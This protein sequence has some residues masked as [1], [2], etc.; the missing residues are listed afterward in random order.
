MIDSVLLRKGLRILVRR[1]LILG[2]LGCVGIT[3]YWYFCEPCHHGW[4][5]DLHRNVDR[6]NGWIECQTRRSTNDEW[7]LPRPIFV[8]NGLRE[9]PPNLVEWQK[10]QE[11]DKNE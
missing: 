8:G 9:L 2:T 5:S 6:G 10:R 1:I 7:G 4:L 3:A 11:Q